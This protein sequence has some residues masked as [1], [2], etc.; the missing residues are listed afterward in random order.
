MAS[1]EQRT[2]YFNVVFYFRGKKCTRS[3][4]TKDKK[5]ANTRR[6]RLEETIR[7][8]E[9]GRL[10]IPEEADAVTF[11]LSDGHIQQPAG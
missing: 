3:L 7:L 10:V 5:E 2:D 4:R 8:V 6:V 9:S 1:L 11:L